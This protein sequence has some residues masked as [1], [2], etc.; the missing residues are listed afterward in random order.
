[1][2]CITFNKKNNEIILLLLLD[3]YNNY[4]QTI[5]LNNINDIA[6][7]DFVCLVK[8]NKIKKFFYNNE[9]GIIIQNELTYDYCK[10]IKLD[11][12]DELFKTLLKQQNKK[13][14]FYIESDKLINYN[15]MIKDDLEEYEERYN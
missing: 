10:H 1:M 9:L 13:N 4:I 5:I 14:N 6:L 11:N 8:Q 7:A 12:Y 15:E 2:E 3:L